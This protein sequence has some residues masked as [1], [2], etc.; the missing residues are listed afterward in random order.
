MPDKDTQKSLLSIVVD[1][2]VHPSFRSD[3]DT[4]FRGRILI[5][6]MLAFVAVTVCA[7]V[8]VLATPFLSTSVFWATLILPPSTLL[9]TALLILVKRRGMYLFSSIAN[10]MVIFTIIV[11]GIC[12][13]GGPAQSPVVQLLVIPPLTAYFFGGLRWGGMAVGLSFIALVV[14]HVI[15]FPFLQTV[16]TEAQMALARD[17]IAFLNLA[18]ISGMAFIY[19]FTAAALKR[20]RDTEH[21]KYIMLAKTDPLTGLANRRNFDAMLKERVELYGSQSPP[22]RFALGCLDLDGFKPINDQYG[23]AVGDEVLRVISDRLRA[24]LR[25]SDF[26]GRHGGDEFMLLLDMVGNQSA[27]EAMADRMLSSIAQPIKT[28]AGIVGVTGSLGFAMF[29]LDASEI[30]DLMKAADAAMY[31]AK[32]DRGRW[33]FYR[34]DMA[35]AAASSISSAS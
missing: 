2:F 9:F 4:F 18:V 22:R 27:L 19:E 24:A 17:I 31:T 11:V 33:C 25:G 16:T 34:K 29:P 14:L 32:Q 13:S 21:E 8:A 5:A 12:V 26:V 23:H 15:G 35:P 20:E 7:Y 28:S 10:V 3:S 1:R 30:E 6:S